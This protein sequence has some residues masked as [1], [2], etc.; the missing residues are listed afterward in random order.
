MI[1]EELI[2][3]LE[4][5]IVDNENKLR[6][7]NLIRF[8]YGFLS[9][10]WPT[11]EEAAEEYG[12]GT[13]ER[14]RQL[15][16]NKFRDRVRL[17]DMPSATALE[18]LISSRPYWS[19]TDLENSVVDQGLS[20][21][22]PNIKG[23]FN[24]LDDLGIVHGYEIYTPELSVLTRNALGN[25]YQ[26]FVIRKDKINQIIGLYRAAKKLPGRCGVARLDYLRERPFCDEYYL[27]LKELVRFSRLSWVK[28][29]GDEFWYLFEGRD[30]TLI[31]YSEKVFSLLQGCDASRL[32]LT[33]RNALNG[34]S[35]KHPYPPAN[36]VQ[37]YLESSIY[38]ANRGGYLQFIGDTEPV[39]EIENDVVSFLKER[40][41]SRYPVIRNY[42]SD[43][44]YGNPH[45]VKAVTSSP[46]VYV[47][48]SEGRGH[49]KYSL[50]GSIGGRGCTDY[51]WGDRYNEF[52]LMLRKLSIKETD[53]DTNSKRRTE[54][55]LLQKWLFA[56]KDYENCAICGNRYSIRSLVAAHKKKRSGC[57][58][59]ERLDPHIV[60]PLCLFGCD[61]LYEIGA[62]RIVDHFVV[63]IPGCFDF[64]A[65]ACYIDRVKERKVEERWLEGPKSYFA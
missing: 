15:K 10:Q 8:F 11:L 39:T 12:I 54:Q 25:Y 1:E 3:F 19:K 27:L 6:D 16:Q 62:I 17:A 29:Y 50:V 58:E 47:D 18:R 31:N 51:E 32:A 56:E 55:S 46:F 45:I 2:A 49:Y 9:S 22:K 52:L 48:R 37:E 53:Q 13:R 14:V 60:M 30:N 57:S 28:E 44:G 7:V 33:Y 41:Y 61:Y 42:L 24:L 35:Y 23:L 36:I 4:Q 26:Y 59:S 20:D 63:S 34:R 21:A 65:E 43:K 64:K 38:F 5:N 40:E